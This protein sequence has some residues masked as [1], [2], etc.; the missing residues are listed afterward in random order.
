MHKF[1][2]YAALVIAA[3]AVSAYTAGRY[4]C[5]HTDSTLARWLHTADAAMTEGVA[6][7]LGEDGHGSSSVALAPADP[8][9]AEIAPA[10][11]PPVIKIEDRLGKNRLPGKIVIDEQ[12]EPGKTGADNTTAKEPCEVPPEVRALMKG[13]QRLEEAQKLGVEECM[14]TGPIMPYC[15]D[16]EP[17]LAT[18]MP[19]AEDAPAETT[20]HWTFFGSILDFFRTPSAG[21]TESCEPPAGHA[22]DCQEDPAYHHQYP[23]CPYNGPCPKSSNVTPPAKSK[24]NAAPFGDE[25]QESSPESKTNFD[26][27]K[28]IKKGIGPERKSKVDTTECR[29]SDIAFGLIG[30]RPF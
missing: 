13:L 9:P 1:F 5:N 2:G 28:L 30:L 20:T 14:P 10:G 17:E 23:G 25:L 8:V 26:A 7:A 19:H 12:E 27:K 3:G 4:A 18:V 24:K 21:A 11:C 6:P 29:P 15:E 16:E 22:P